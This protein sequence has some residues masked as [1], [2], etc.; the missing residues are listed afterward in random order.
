[1]V[2]KTHSVNFHGK[3]GEFL[4][5]WIVNILLTIVTLSIYSA[6]AKVRTNRYFYG[7]TEIDGDRFEYLAQPMQI[8]KGRIVAMLMLGA[9]FLTSNLYPTAAGILFLAFAA[10]FPF[11]AVKNL[12][13]SMQM[14]RYR[15]IRFTFKGSMKGGYW[16]FLGRPIIALV[17][18]YVP[19]FIILFSMM[20]LNPETVATAEMDE[21]KALASA[22][23]SFLFIPLGGVLFLWVKIGIDRYIANGTTFGTIPFSAE[24]S[25]GKYLMIGFKTMG[26]A[27]LVYL[28][29]GLIIVVMALVFGIAG[30]EDSGVAA[31]LLATFSI[32]LIFAFTILATIVSAFFQGR[33]RNYIFEQ[34]RVA[35]K[36]KLDSSIS[37][38]PF[39]TVMATN[40]LAIVFSLGLAIPWA[41]VRLTRYMAE[42]TFVN[43]DLSL[44]TAEQA[45]DPATSALG[46]EVAEAFDMEVGLV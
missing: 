39:A 28:S 13:F 26:V 33:I 14:T 23:I 30:G 17:L 43:G 16:T 9:W 25:F 24:L 20:G 19:I 10:I 11:L 4:G 22:V 27:L 6:W 29:F 5:I 21:S 42:N 32:P 45:A 1:V 7:N 36:L 37:T 3:G 35:D 38:L 31:A 40:L 44:T 34:A 15:N 8:L 46:D 12:R 18:F 41:K 2:N